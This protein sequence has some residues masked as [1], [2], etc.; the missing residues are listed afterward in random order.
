MKENQRQKKPGTGRFRP[1]RLLGGAA[2]FL[3]LF[4]LAGYFLADPPDPGD[5][6]VSPRVMD[7]RG[8]TLYASL[9]PEDELVVPCSLMEMGKVLPSVAVGV[10]DKRFYDHPGVDPLA[11][12]RAAWQNLAGRRVVSGASTITVQLVRLSRPRERTFLSKV[13]EFFEAL[14]L[15]REYTKDQILELYLNRAPFGG[16]LRG[17][18]AASLA[19]FQKKPADLTLGESALLVALL[20]GPSVYRPDR[21]PERARARRDVVL[22]RLLGRG[23]IT[24]EQYAAAAA[25]PVTPV[26]H[27]PPRLAPHLSMRLIAGEGRENFRW[28]GGLRFG[29]PTTID[30]AVQLSLEKRLSDALRPMPRNINAAGLVLSNKNGHVLA[31]VGGL[32]AEGEGSFVDNVVSLRSPGSTLKPFVYLEAFASGALAPDSL[33]ADTPLSL[34][35]EAPRNF[36]GTYRGPVS[37]GAALGRSLNAPAV[38]VL[39]LVGEDRA[40]EVLSE[41]G[42]EVPRL[43]SFGDSLV[44]GGLEVSLWSLAGAYG[45]LASGG[46]AVEPTLDP[47][48]TGAGPRVFSEAASWLVNSSLVAEKRLPR[49]VSAPGAAMKSGTSNGRRDAWMA[50]YDPARTAVLWLGDPAG[51]AEAS[52]SGTASLAESAAGLMRDLGPSPPWPGPPVGVERYLSC[53]VSGEP[54]GPFCPGSKWS[55][56][57]AAGAR[58]VPC[59][60]HARRRGETVTLWPAEL[61][62]MMGGPDPGRRAAPS[63]PRVVSPAQGSVVVMDLS[64]VRDALP[65]KSEDTSGLVHWYLDDRYFRSADRFTTPVVR[66]AP[67]PHRVALI[68]ERHRTTVSEFTVVAPERPAADD[69]A[70]LLEFD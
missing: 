25:E 57:V 1:L 30:P 14:R 52:L 7:R 32:R 23:L 37:A 45:S 53:P 4:F 11:V 60:L 66:L 56:R 63:R 17:A 61:A 44:L 46:T 5:F 68:D 2:A 58:T 40:L 6:F 26:V 67:G 47:G 27:R 18:G 50:A 19:Y 35:G 9:T 15:E 16:N 31:Y 62:P 21:W 20:R 64:D 59:G 42:F 3:L 54:A 65:L 29:V 34:G 22:G 8:G 70:P 43:R 12:L 10:E 24:S 48:R 51:R 39:R 28:R 41:A 49:G 33:L 38:R 13:V 55:H 36:D 69:P